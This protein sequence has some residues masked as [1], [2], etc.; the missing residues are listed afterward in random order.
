MRL[1]HITDPHLTTLHGIAL[2]RLRG[3][4]LLGYLSWY[5]KRRNQHCP[6]RLAG[7]VEAITED[8]PD[9]ILVTGDL[10]HIGFP[11]EIAA[12]Q[13]WLDRLGNIARTLL[14]PGNHDLYATDSW[15][16]VRDL[17]SPYLWP[18]GTGGGRQEFPSSLDCGHVGL[19]GLSS[20]CPTA[21]FSAGGR[22][23]GAQR[24]R[25]AACLQRHAVARRFRCLLIHHPPLRGITNRRRALADAA[26]LETILRRHGVELILHGHL[27]RNVMHRLGRDTLVFGTASASS[28]V[29]TRDAAYRIFDIDIQDPG[30][31]VNMVLKT[32]TPRRR[33][34]VLHEESWVVRTP[35]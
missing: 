18:G 26:E 35:A 16:P 34:W 28:C 8:K 12:A 19:I 13:P 15:E 1:V 30:W 3:K 6:E 23:G 24:Q 4:R 27:H 25:L 29:E 32:I 17:W 11:E 31:Q 7:L 20:A 21:F 9:R 22:L 5:R 33:A 14:V 10:T 2:G